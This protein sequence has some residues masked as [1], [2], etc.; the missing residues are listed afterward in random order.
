MRASAVGAGQFHV[1]AVSGRAD[2]VFRHA[3]DAS[4]RDLSDQTTGSV[5]RESTVVESTTEGATATAHHEFTDGDRVNDRSTAMQSGA[6]AARTGAR[7]MMASCAPLQ[8]P[9]SPG[10]DR[11]SSTS[12]KAEGRVVHGAVALATLT[13]VRDSAAG[14]ARVGGVG[15]ERPPESPTCEAARSSGTVEQAATASASGANPASLPG[16]RNG[17]SASGAR[18][19][20]AEET[21]PSHL[22]AT[23]RP[24]LPTDQQDPRR[25]NGA[26]RQFI[27]DF[28]RR[29]EQPPDRH[30]P[31]VDLP[32]RS[33]GCSGRRHR[34]GARGGQHEVQ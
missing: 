25:A 34:A 10:Q 19:P 11:P 28:R 5:A 2:P 6:H 18:P 13:P 9:Q 32:R 23:S 24:P 30:P 22:R 3:L 27:T 29:S 14:A 26:S 17:A 8:S 20:C 31:R 16:R 21:R 1:A 33:G 4:A 15:H 12:S 7:A